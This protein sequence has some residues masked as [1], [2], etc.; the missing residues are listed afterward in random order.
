M[1]IEEQ[2]KAEILSHYKSVRAFTQAINIPYSTLDSAFKRGIANSGVGTMVKVFQALD[3]D[4]EN[5]QFG[6]LKKAAPSE[7]E[8]LLSLLHQL[9]EEGREKLLDYAADLVA[10]GRYIKIDSAGL[11]KEA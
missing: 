5:V 2:L 3:L 10:S 6:D 11:G 1:T 7:D 4:I 8:S 9:N